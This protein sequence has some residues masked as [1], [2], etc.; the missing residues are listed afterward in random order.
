MYNEA[1]HAYYAKRH[2]TE[3]DWDFFCDHLFHS[4]S[5]K[6][7]KSKELEKF[8]T[9]RDRLS[10]MFCITCL[11]LIPSKT[12]SQQKNMDFFCINYVCWFNVTTL[13]ID[14]KRGYEKHME[15]DHQQS[16]V[17]YPCD[18]C[19]NTFPEKDMTASTEDY[20]PHWISHFYFNKYVPL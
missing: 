16:P 5:V 2:L 8:L 7:E 15:T 20:Y 17:L 13:Y 6:S 1:T 18:I 19:G 9:S 14:G 12:Y 3:K 10:K 11:K 4:N